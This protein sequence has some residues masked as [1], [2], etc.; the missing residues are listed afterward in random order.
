MQSIT[1]RA[2]A[3]INW[4]LMVT[5]KREDG[6]HTL[7]MVMQSINLFDTIT[8]SPSSRIN[9]TVNGSYRIPTGNKNIAYKAA[10][11]LID[12]YSLNGVNIFINKRIPVCGGM[13]GGSTDAAGVLLAMDRLFG[14][15]MQE[16]E[17]KETALSLG[18]DV[19]FQL[20]GGLARA[21]GVGEEL[22]YYDNCQTYWLVCYSPRT[23]ASTAAVFGKLNELTYN[24]D[25]TALIEALLK[26]DFD[27]IASNMHNDLEK[28]TAS[29]VPDIAVYRQALLQTGPVAVQMTG[30]G[31]T[32]FALYRNRHEAEKA[33]KALPGKSFVCRTINRSVEYL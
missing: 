5:G 6:Y 20:R 21:R 31:S 9:I 16:T 19:P 2:N 26:R 11:K 8:V 14:L 30:S 13:A 7:D 1:V 25:N 29:L 12:R 24:A 4:S 22:E 33:S 3:K 18:A 27:G 23:G 17:F 15:N 32:V 10:E 28:V